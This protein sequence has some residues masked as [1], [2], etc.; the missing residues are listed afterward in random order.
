T[1]TR[2]QV[3]GF[4]STAGSPLGLA[5][6][7]SSQGPHQISYGLNYTFFNALTVSW[8]GQFRSGSYYTPLVAGDINGDGYFNDRAF[9]YPTTT[10]A[11]SATKAGMTSL[12]ANSAPSVKA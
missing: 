8:N 11:D 10:T 9:I 3:S 2:E 12:L 6:A 7:K 5:W 1:S 4:N